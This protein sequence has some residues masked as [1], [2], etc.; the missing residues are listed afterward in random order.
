[1]TPPKPIQIEIAPGELVDKITILEIKCAR[2]ADPGKLSNVRIELE[3]LTAARDRAVPTSP[4]FE[5]LTAELKR[6][7]EALWEIEDE[8]RDCERR[9]EFGPEFVRL[10][11]SVYQTNDRRAAVKRQLNELLGSKLLEEKSYAVY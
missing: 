3:S 9:Q 6:L 4:R 7:N 10:A 1:M 11:R 8:I 5:S 2:I